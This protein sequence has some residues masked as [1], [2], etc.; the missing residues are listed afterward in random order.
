M[1]KPRVRRAG[2]RRECPNCGGKMRKGTG[3]RAVML[4]A[5][6]AAAWAVV[7]SRCTATAV[8]VVAPKA[9]TVAPPCVNKCGG[10][11][12]FCLGCYERAAK[13]VGDLTAANIVLREGAPK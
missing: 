9:V 1:S 8:P 10:T 2:A 13:H 11:A 7:C 4:D 12:A 5:H 3:T 6:G